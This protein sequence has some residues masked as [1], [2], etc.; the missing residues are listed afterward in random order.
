MSNPR[1]PKESF[2]LTGKSADF[3]KIRASEAFETACDYA[4]LELLWH[5]PPNN[6]PNLPTDPYVGIDANAQLFGAKR[7]IEILKTIAEPVKPVE[8]P[9]RPTLSYLQH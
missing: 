9:K 6:T 5:M 2:Q 8:P 3:A 4:L 7:I 1:S